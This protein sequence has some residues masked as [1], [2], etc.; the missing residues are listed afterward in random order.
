MYFEQCFISRMSNSACFGIGKVQR[1][2]EFSFQQSIQICDSGLFSHIPSQ[3]K[4]S[5][6]SVAVDIVSIWNISSTLQ[7]I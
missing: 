2:K 4:S 5:F 3:E 7:R 6:L 1:H